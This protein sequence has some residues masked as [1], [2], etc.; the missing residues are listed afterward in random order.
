M[1]VKCHEISHPLFN[2]VTKGTSA[3]LF[4]STAKRRRSKMQIEEE[5]RVEKK[6]K[7]E[8]DIKVARFDEMREQSLKFKKQ[9]DDTQQEMAEQQVAVDEIRDLYNQGLIHRDESGRMRP[10]VDPKWQEHY[11][12]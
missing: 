11:R 3:H 8:V 7:Q 9:L 6:Q 12:T 4:K 1:V 2:I 5:K 10:I